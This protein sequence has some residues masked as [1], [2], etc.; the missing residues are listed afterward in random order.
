MKHLIATLSILVAS[1]VQAANVISLRSMDESQKSLYSS[2]LFSKVGGESFKL[3]S[4]DAADG[5]SKYQELYKG[6]PVYGHVV[7]LKKNNQSQIE[8]MHGYLVRGI[9]ADVPSVQ[10]KIEETAAVTAARAHFENIYGADKK[11]GYRDL[12]SSL[13]IFVDDSGKA[14]LAYLVKFFADTPAGTNPA[15][16]VIFVDATTGKV[17]RFTNQLTHNQVEVNGPGGNKKTGMYKYGVDRKGIQIEHDAATG[18]CTMDT[19]E[20]MTV[21]LAGAG[22]V[23]DPEKPIPDST[24]YSFDCKVLP[25]RPI[26]GAW[27]PLNDAH[28][29]GVAVMNMYK[30]WFNQSPL[31]VKLKMRVH[32][33]KDFEN[34]YWDGKSMTFGDGGANLYPLATALDVTGHEISHGFTEFN[35]NLEYRSESGSINE[36]F[37]DMAGEAVEFYLNGHNDFLIGKEVVKEGGA[38]KGEALRYMADPTKDTQ[39]LLGILSVGS[40]DN[41]KNFKWP[42]NCDQLMAASGGIFGQLLYIA[43]CTDMHFG[44]GLYNKAFYLMATAPGQN[45][46]TAFMVFQKAN[47]NYWT[48]KTN[49]VDGAKGVRDAAQDLGFPTDVVTKAFAAVGVNIR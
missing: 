25:G 5:I 4:T 29:N 24:P 18:R 37:S 21:D 28:V 33:G 22:D 46:K 30:E 36:A 15:R 32:F 43:Q 17:L 42:E 35:S 19:G 6:V 48:A 31:K 12:E 9:Q 3:I 44:S 26:N 23:N 13:Q 39:D 45:A 11:F 14:S 10:P 8:R 2:N 20:V 41:A 16:P 1:Q 49:F 34:A 7:V 47:K 27:A 40:I 38:I